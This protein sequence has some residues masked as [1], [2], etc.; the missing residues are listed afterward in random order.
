MAILIDG[1]SASTSEIFA[2]GLQDLGRARIFGTRSAA[3]ALPSAIER[4]PNGD[5]FQHAIANYIS[6]GGRVLEG[7]GVI[8][9]VVVELK[10]ED[11]LRG[12]DAVLKAALTWIETQ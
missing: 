7:N 8:P 11:L 1:H 10:R 5:G 9:D 2:G 4:L 6:E 12:V 3:A